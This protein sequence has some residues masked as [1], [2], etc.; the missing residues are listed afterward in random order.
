MLPAEKE[1]RYKVYVDFKI[2]RM[3]TCSKLY[4]KSREDLSEAA[5]QC[6]FYNALIQFFLKSLKYTGKPFPLFL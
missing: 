1:I 3:L 6:I 5:N 4:V 2:F